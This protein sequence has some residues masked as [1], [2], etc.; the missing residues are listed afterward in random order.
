[1]QRKSTFFIRQGTDKKA[2]GGP[3]AQASFR[4]VFRPFYSIAS[5]MLIGLSTLGCASGLKWLRKM[6]TV[7]LVSSFALGWH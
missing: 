1:M 7:G 5:G 2:A 3:G 4:Q 6:S